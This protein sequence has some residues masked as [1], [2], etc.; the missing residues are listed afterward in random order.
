MQLQ[1]LLLSVAASNTGMEEDHIL[2]K[3][4]EVKLGASSYERRKAAASEIENLIKA[5]SEKGD[6][7][8]IRKM[9]RYLGDEYVRSPQPNF[10]K[11]GL[12]GLATCAVALKDNKKPKTSP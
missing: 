9:I 10:R 1:T 3:E 5:L 6:D 8:K 2:P 11:G 12:L 7:G 4:I